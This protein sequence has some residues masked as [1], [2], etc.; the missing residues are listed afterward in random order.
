MKQ[1]LQP[2][3]A[4]GFAVGAFSPRTTAVIP[5]ILRAAQAEHSPALIQIAEPELEMYGLTAGQFAEAFFRVLEEINPGVPVGLHLDHTWNFSVIRDAV[6]A[7]FSS[8]MVDASAYPLEE[9]IRRVREVAAYA[10]ARGVSVEAELGRIAN[11][12]SPEGTSDEEKYTVP[13]EASV[14]VR[15]TGVDALAV[16]VGTSH[17]VSRTREQKIDLPHLARIRAAT[18]VH[19]VLHG[20]SGVPA[21]M[22]RAAIS[23]PGGGVSKIN[24]ATDLETAFMH[25]L[26]HSGRLSDAEANALPAEDLQRAL[27]AVEAVVRGKMCNF[28]G[29]S[30][31]AAAYGDSVPESEVN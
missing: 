4:G 8:V 19:L 31:R 3:E 6:A 22:I 11:A 14:F 2:A 24:I 30:G 29:S 16:S 13:E 12:D 7:G 18:S 9:N 28:L 17:G 26:G 21:E 15:H 1:A 23:L 27:A 5:A 25:A 10:H 20:G